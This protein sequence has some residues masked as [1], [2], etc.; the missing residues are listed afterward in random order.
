MLAPVVDGVAACDV[1][2][3]APAALPRLLA[4]GAAFVAF[5]EVAAELTASALVFEA[6]DDGVAAV[7]GVGFAFE[8]RGEVRV[9]EAVFGDEARLRV[10]VI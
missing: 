10:E 6:A 5:A 1:R 7:F 2:P 8:V 4:V 3:R 9:A